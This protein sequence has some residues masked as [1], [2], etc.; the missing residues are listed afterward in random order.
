MPSAC[1]GLGCSFPSAAPSTLKLHPPAARRS[2]AGLLPAR[3]DHRRAQGLLPGGEGAARGGR[4]GFGAAKGRH[5]GRAG[6]GLAGT[7]AHRRCLHSAAA[8]PEAQ[9]RRCVKGAVHVWTRW[10]CRRW[11][12]TCGVLKSAGRVLS[13]RQHEQCCEQNTALLPNPAAGGVRGTPLSCPCAGVCAGMCSLDPNSLDPTAHNPWNGQCGS[14]DE[15]GPQQSSTGA[16][17]LRAA[18]LGCAAGGRATLH[19][20]GHVCPELGLL[21]RS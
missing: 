15:A 11:R 1:I 5:K 17:R 7:V 18:A 10:S 2:N 21:L 8:V 6:A 4:G 3:L 13:T 9:C 12:P 14:G 19:Y 20:H 16:S